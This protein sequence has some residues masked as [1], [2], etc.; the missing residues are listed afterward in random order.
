MVTEAL[1]IVTRSETAVITTFFT[2][3]QNQLEAF[4][5]SLN[6]PF[7]R[8]EAGQII[9]ND[10]STVF[11]LNTQSLESSSVIDFL[12]GCSKASHLHFL[13]VGHYPLP[14]PEANVLNMLSKLGSGISIS[15]WVSLED[16]LLKTF[17]GDRLLTMMETL[18]VKDDECIEHSLVS[19]SISNAR[20]KIAEKVKVEISANSEEEWF[21]KNLRK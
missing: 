14:T 20:V 4:L 1:R 15:F 10:R 13:F 21:E 18:G 5:T 3:T 2:E 16:P 17:G 12:S 9:E 11:I 8:V 7:K 19:K 6:V